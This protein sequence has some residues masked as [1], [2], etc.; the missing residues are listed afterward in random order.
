MYKGMLLIDGGI[1][2]CDPF[3]F[4]GHISFLCKTESKMAEINW[5]ALA[6]YHNSLSE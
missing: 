6:R 4:I 1:E 3:S 5:V 2:K